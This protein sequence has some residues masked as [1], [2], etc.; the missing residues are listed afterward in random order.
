[1]HDF[2]LRQRA[3]F[4][5]PRFQGWGR[6]RQYFEGWYFKVVVPEAGLAYAFIP[7][8][9][10][11]AGGKGHSFLQVLDGVAAT[12]SYHEYT[13]NDF[14]PAAYRFDVQLGPH[15]FSTERLRVDLPELQVDLSFR[16]IHPWTPRRLARGVMGWYGFVPK[17]QCY[18][19]LVSFHHRMRGTIRVGDTTHDAASGV[20]Y[21]EKDWGRGF[22]DAWIWGQSNHLSDARGPASLM[23]SV[24]SI[25]WMGTAFRGFLCT[26]LLEGEMYIFTTWTGAQ[27]A[28]TFSPEGTSVTV[29]FFNSRYHLTVTG[30]PAPGGQLASPIQGAMTGKINESLRAELDVRLE[31]DG[32]LVYAGTATWAGLE[33]SDNARARL[34]G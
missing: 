26:L 20:G 29:T 17:M 7:G 33:V 3:T 11:D 18:H 25:P 9:S 30:H 12:S 24:A 21:T 4:D 6:H 34:A 13:T 15:R 5:P 19:G 2:L 27:S 8:I 28:V 31:R 16:G 23:L 1:M 22:P 14:R 10:Y 32:S